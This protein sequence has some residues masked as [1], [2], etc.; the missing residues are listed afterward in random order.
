MCSRGQGNGSLLRWKASPPSVRFHGLACDDS[1]VSETKICSVHKKTD[2]AGIPG[3][4][5]NGLLHWH[6]VFRALATHSYHFSF[7]RRHESKFVAYE[8]LNDEPML[9]ELLVPQR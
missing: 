8:E 6:G 2:M 5:G 9:V 1:A 7:Q 3:M 4:F